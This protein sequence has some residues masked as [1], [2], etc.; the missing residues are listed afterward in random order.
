MFLM[1]AD[2]IRIRTLTTFKPEHG[3]LSHIHSHWI[4]LRALE[5]HCSGLTAAYSLHN[6]TVD[7]KKKYRKN[8][9]FLER[10]FLSDV[11]RKCAKINNSCTEHRP[12]SPHKHLHAFVP[13]L[14][15]QTWGRFQCIK[16]QCWQM[17][18]L[19]TGC[20]EQK[21][22]QGS[23]PHT[24]PSVFATQHPLISAKMSKTKFNNSHA[25]LDLI[26]KKK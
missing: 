12:S 7:K 13:G 21:P 16:P 2:K 17:W 19:L 8:T 25:I 14:Q 20:Q 5:R 23:C 6:R 22:T 4:T 1:A 9:A 3:L 18:R 26:K 24:H 11:S 10:D 15:V